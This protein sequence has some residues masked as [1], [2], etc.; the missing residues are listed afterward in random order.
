MRNAEGLGTIER[1]MANSRKMI[2]EVNKAMAGQSKIIDNL[3]KRNMKVIEMLNEGQAK[4][5]N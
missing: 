5:F 4:P 3:I 1:T 2:A